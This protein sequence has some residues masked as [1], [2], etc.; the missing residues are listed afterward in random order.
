M[1]PTLE[2]ESSISVSIVP[3]DLSD[4]SECLS[5]PDRVREAGVEAIDILINNAGLAKGLDT[6][7]ESSV[8]DIDAMFDVNV[9]AL[10]LLCRGFVSDMIKRDRGHIINIGS[11]AGYDTYPNGAVYCATKYAVRAFTEALQKEV[12]FI[13][14]FLPCL[15]HL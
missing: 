10:I 1:Q 5:L 2:N 8:S 15:G 12:V 14:M 9:R 7:A 6:V 3:A 4:E 11:I 13:L